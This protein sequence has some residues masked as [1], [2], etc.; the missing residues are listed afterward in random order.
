MKHVL[1]VTC[2]CSMNHTDRDFCQ[3]KGIV[4]KLSTV[5]SPYSVLKETPFSCKRHYTPS[6][7]GLK[8]KWVYCRVVLEKLEEC[9]RYGPNKVK[10]QTNLEAFFF[11]LRNYH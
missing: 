1:V 3:N 10:K 6:A 7:L 8:W 11:H 5:F 9:L 4:W 2:A